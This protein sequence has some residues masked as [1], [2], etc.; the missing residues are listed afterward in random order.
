MCVTCHK[1]YNHVCLWFIIGAS[2][3]LHLYKRP[4]W[5][6]LY[7]HNFCNILFGERRSCDCSHWRVKLELKWTAT[8]S[9]DQTNWWAHSKPAS[10]L[11]FSSPQRLQVK[12][13]ASQ[14]GATVCCRFHGQFF[15][16]KCF[17]VAD[18]WGSWAPS[19]TIKQEPAQASQKF[20]VGSHWALGPS[21]EEKGFACEGGARGSSWTRA[22]RRC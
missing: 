15:K 20:A 7:E 10:S 18:R 13:F 3:K 11:C 2:I 14:E 5:F 16:T 8:K 17:Q 12:N 19:D 21:S 9:T 1:S 22:P 6:N 4:L